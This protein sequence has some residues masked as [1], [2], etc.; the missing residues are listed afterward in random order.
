MK[1]ILV[2]LLISLTYAPSLI[3][4]NNLR[5]VNVRQSTWGPQGTIEKAVLSIHPKGSYVEQGLYLTFSDR[6]NY[7][8]PGDSLE[9]QFDFELP[10]EAYV[11]DLWLWVE[12]SLMRALIMDRWTATN[13]YEGIV[14][15][16]RD[17]SLLTINDYGN[18]LQCKL[19]IFPL[20]PGTTRRIKMTF[21][22][23][24]VWTKSSVQCTLPIQLLKSSLNQVTQSYIIFW[25]E[26]IWHNPKFPHDPNI[27]F[28]A[29]LDELQNPFFR[30]QIKDVNS[31]SSLEIKYDNVMNNGIFL[32]TYSSGEDHF[33]Q[34]A[35]LPQQLIT[36]QPKLRK[37]LFLMDFLPN[38][39]PANINA[40]I[41]LNNLQALLIEEYA[42]RDSFNIIFS[43]FQNKI[44]SNN[45]IPADDQTVS[46]IFSTL[47][48]TD[49]SGYSN[50]PSLFADGIS[51]MQKHQSQ[52]EMVLVSNS[53]NFGSKEQANSLIKDILNAMNQRFAI[54]VIDLNVSNYPYYWIDDRYYYG[55]EYFNINISRFT[56]GEYFSL[57]QQS[58]SQMLYNVV[59]A[60]GGFFSSFDVYTT[61][62]NGYTYSRFDLFQN[63]GRTYFNQPIFQLGRFIGQFPFHIQISGEYEG[64]T[65][66]YQKDVSQADVVLGDSCI[67]SI[68]IGK[69]IDQLK[70]QTRINSVISE[71][72]DLSLQNRVLTD[73]TALLALEP[74]DTVH[75]SKDLYDESV[76]VSVEDIEQDSIKTDF[77]LNAFPNP[78]NTT[79]N[80]EFRIPADIKSSV[81]KLM[82]YNI[83][84]QIVK[85]F[86]IPVTPDKRKYSVLWDG[87]NEQGNQISSGIYIATL[88]VDKIAKSIRLL[89]LK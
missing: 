40:S 27:K 49:F 39:A 48:S 64:E 55:N 4:S 62:N 35:I 28:T 78:F 71:M 82:I 63:L 60:L 87:L 86:D 72:I 67:K 10:K 12:D 21:L 43:K 17:P 3:S 57:R 5:V 61:V 25:P 7:F 16:R 74:S 18:Y 66:F 38:N 14:K 42:D 46:A 44:L 54:Y 33:Y 89:Y 20:M 31:L 81:I 41:L 84:G 52:G 47:N 11:T 50:L 36:L 53:T 22:T 69:R 75:A 56:K 30:A 37:S 23:P 15:R 80:L 13:I 58:L 88:K 83:T 77:K 26:S 8:S 65:I 19:R 70:T 2:L 32:N 68:W 59:S 45:W 6:G 24:A 1:K 85:T 51:F 29:D 76:L 73:Y 79:T 34:L 9:I